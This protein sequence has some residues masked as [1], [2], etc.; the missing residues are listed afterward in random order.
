[1]KLQLGQHADFH[2][3]QNILD[4]LKHLKINLYVTGFHFAHFQFLCKEV[5][6]MWTNGHIILHAFKIFFDICFPI[7]CIYSL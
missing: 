5:S 4:I 3:E 1:M 6:Y 2:N 7:D